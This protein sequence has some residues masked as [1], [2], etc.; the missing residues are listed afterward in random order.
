MLI[1]S[2]NKRRD[3]RSRHDGYLVYT[4]IIL[5]FFIIIFVSN[6]FYIDIVNKER[7]EKTF[8]VNQVYNSI[9]ASEN[10]DNAAESFWLDRDVSDVKYAEK[11]LKKIVDL[12]SFSSIELTIVE[13]NKPNKSLLLGEPGVPFNNKAPVLITLAKD[14]SYYVKATISKK[15]KSLLAPVDIG[16]F[17]LPFTVFSILLV[18]I[19]MTSFL[20]YRFN[21]VIDL[22]RRESSELKNLLLESKKESARREENL[23]T[24]GHDIRTPF[25]YFGQIQSN[26]LSKIKNIDSILKEGDGDRLRLAV[27]DMRSYLYEFERTRTNFVETWI[28]PLLVEIDKSE[29]ETT[30]FNL[31]K[32]LEMQI[33]STYSVAKG[34]SAGIYIDYYYDPSV[35]K[36]LFYFQ[37]DLRVIFRNILMNAISSLMPSFG[38]F[39]KVEPY[40]FNG[41]DVVSIVIE[42][43]GCGIPENI[44]E[45]I[46]EEGV[47]KKNNK[48]YVSSGVGMSI[49]KKKADA[50]NLEIL[51][52]S[53][54][55]KGTKVTLV[56]KTKPIPKKIFDRVENEKLETDYSVHLFSPDGGNVDW[57]RGVLALNPI[58]ERF[59][60]WFKNIDIEVFSLTKKSL[61]SDYPIDLKNGKHIIFILDPSSESSLLQFIL[62]K[63]KNIKYF[64]VFERVREFEILRDDIEKIKGSKFAPLTLNEL[65]PS[66]EKINESYPDR[67]TSSALNES[68]EKGLDSLSELVGKKCLVID[69]AVDGFSY[70]SV[71]LKE[72]GL[73]LSYQQYPE[74]ALDKIESDNV[75][76][77]MVIIDY[78]MPN[79]DG[80]EVAK[81][82]REKVGKGIMLILYT[83][84]FHQ[85]LKSKINSL[86]DKGTL[87]GVLDKI[88]GISIEDIAAHYYRY[89]EKVSISMLGLSS[90]R[91]DN[92]TVIGSD[93]KKSLSL[94]IYKNIEKIIS[95]VESKA[96]IIAFISEEEIDSLAFMVHKHA[97]G[98]GSLPGASS[99]CSE[100]YKLENAV[101]RGIDVKQHVINL[102]K[103]YLEYKKIFG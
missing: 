25:S 92:Q 12:S 40:S 39:V 18:I 86:I 62:P 97:T 96:D 10:T 44:L 13:K 8:I 4:L 60:G 14:V 83:S 72:A 69:D 73:D 85:D 87:D 2:I 11:I 16:Y 48:N 41:E 76:Y 33:D 51:I 93:D 67:I 95:T 80:I 15:K 84:N 100:I 57:P 46:F 20:L 77:D 31:Y 29:K 71:A 17:D 66:I 59:K 19:F 34:V 58:V 36:I 49:V 90:V 21:K 23:K 43:Q 99:L 42:D 22:N 74:E 65:M 88:N 30:E 3:R 64:V 50:H 102:E 54:I 75:F 27:R 47:R 32:M 70:Y 61:L 38:V 26:L 53:T 37:N 103:E 101:R 63:N 81:R 35:P 28:N 55:N 1:S 24:L 89:R 79:I 78:H 7:S 52:E 56:L 98:V 9:L 5:S 94:P 91:T 68:M 82:I 45:H 6:I